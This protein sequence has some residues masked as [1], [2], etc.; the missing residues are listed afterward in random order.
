ME[1]N[2]LR[3]GE[4]LEKPKVFTIRDLV[5][6]FVGTIIPGLIVY[7]VWRYYNSSGRQ[8]NFYGY[9]IFGFIP[10]LAGAIAGTISNW[11]VATPRATS[12]LSGLLINFLC[13]LGLLAFGIE[14]VVC[15]AMAFPL[16][17]PLI[18]LGAFV[19]R[20]VIGFCR[21]KPRILVTSVPVMVAIGAGTVLVN[22]GFMTRT[23]STTVIINAPP[24]KIWPYLFKL[25]DLPDPDQWIFKTGI[26]YTKGTKSGGQF[27]GASRQCLLTTGVMNETISALVPNRYMRFQVLNT[28]PSMK[29]LNP[30]YEIHPRHESGCFKVDWGEFRLEPLSG[31][32][33]WFTGTST[34]SYN[35]YPGWY[36]SLYTD[37]VAEQIHVRMMGEIKRRVEKS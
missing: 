36:W 29:E 11:K 1:L 15:I 30:F 20:A 8:D 4:Q 22:P 33:T 31:G 16:T 14:G 7:L 19:A 26:A 24:E 17:Y 28:P 10:F 5:A 21:S 25:S 3:P 23:E 13:C 2:D 35:I 27:V 37:T 12:W 18:S 9:G 32:R 6:C 34:Y